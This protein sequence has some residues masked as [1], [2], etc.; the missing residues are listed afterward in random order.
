MR[1]PAG[2]FYSATDADSEGEEGKYFVWT[3]ADV[4]RLVEPADA[5]LVCRYWDITEEGNFEGRSI[6]HVTIDVEQVARLFRRPSAEAAT[7]LARARTRML[8]A[9]AERVPPL[10]DEKI[11]VSW[12]ALMIGTLAE[13]GRVLGAARFL[14]AAQAAADFVW[15]HVRRDGR[16]LHVWATG[17][18]RYGGYLD[19]HAFL[20]AALLDLYEAAGDRGHLERAREVMTALDARFRDDGAGG[21]FFNAHDE[22]QLI[23][24]SKPGADGSLPSGNAVAA[25]VLLRLHHLTGEAAYRERAEEILRLYHTEAARNPFGFATYLQALELYLEGPTEVVV[26]AAPDAEEADALWRTVASTYLPHRVLVRAA[27]GEPQPLAPAR[28]RP[29]IDGRATAYVCRHFTCSAP[30]TDPEALR[31]ALN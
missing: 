27:P 13:A 31:A 16:L 24:R 14:D 29:A 9:R 7:A 30:V 21:Y 28:D 1:H 23:A 5:E 2:G 15:Q 12:N 22:E 3:P 8:A 10:R 25:H 20:A 26:I 18:A 19:D 11:L 17:Q 6:P 4:A